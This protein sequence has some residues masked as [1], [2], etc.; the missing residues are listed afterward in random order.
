MHHGAT[1]DIVEI[2]RSLVERFVVVWRAMIVNEEYP[3]KTLFPELVGQVH[4]NRAQRRHTNGI[5]SGKYRLASNRVGRVVAQRNLR[6]E[7]H[8]PARSGDNGLCQFLCVCIYGIAIGINRQ[9]ANSRS[10]LPASC[11]RPSQSGA[12]SRLIMSLVI[13]DLAATLRVTSPSFR[14][15][16]FSIFVNESVLTPL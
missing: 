13:L 3:A 2:I 8:R 1:V 6:K 9:V 4:V 14:V 5:A 12:D 15:F 16:V 7:D 10:D 11:K